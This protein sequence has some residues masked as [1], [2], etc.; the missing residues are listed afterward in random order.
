MQTKRINPGVEVWVEG[1]N[2]H[3]YTYTQREGIV[4]RADIDLYI[5]R[6]GD[7]KPALL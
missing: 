2:T 5:W 1:I 3:T 6:G 4:L 7:H